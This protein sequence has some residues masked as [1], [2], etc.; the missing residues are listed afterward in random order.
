MMKRKMFLLMAGIALLPVWSEAQAA[1]N[2]GK[3]SYASYTPLANCKSTTHSGDQSRS[4][5]Y[6]KLYV[7]ER[8]GQS[9]PTNDWWTN[10]ITDQY[11]G[12]LWAYPQ[13]IQ[14]QQKGL[15]IQ[16]PL[17]WMDDGTE[18]KSNTVLTVSGKN[19]SPAS[20]VA[21]SWH[22]WDVEFSMQD[23]DKR[24]D[25]TMAHGMPFTWIEMHN[26]VPQL[27]LANSGWASA[28]YHADAAVEILDASGSPLSSGTVCSSFV[29]KKD[30]DYYGVYLPS[31][32]EVTID[33][34][35]ATI[36]FSG[37]EQ[38][39]SVAPLNTLA[40][41]TSLAPYA[42]SVPRKTTVSWNYNAAAG[43]VQTYWNIEAGKPER[44]CR[45]GAAGI[46]AA[47]V[48]R[49]GQRR[50]AR[51]YGSQL[52]HSAWKTEDGGRHKIRS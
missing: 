15:D 13:F 35:V 2:V 33:N 12:H 30:A 48:P 50:N 36:H 5:Q 27:S 3:G 9:I 6:R 41:F 46:P 47:S 21:Q 19:F 38:Y 29:M 42:Y 7:T 8:S 17:T 14:A 32:S 11:S 23:A 10:L 22:D 1:V 39:V 37:N 34:A 20:A 18:M 52:F 26:V 45:G 25:V 28:D 16:R 51:L 44:R 31:G 40:D 4:M 43:K 24:F 49:H